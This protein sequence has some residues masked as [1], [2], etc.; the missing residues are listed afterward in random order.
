MEIILLGDPAA[1]KATQA[2]KLSRKFKLIDFDMGEELRKIQFGSGNAKLKKVLA[3]TYSKGKLTPTWLVRSILKKGIYAAPKS[4][5]ILF[6]GFPKMFGE[7]RLASKWLDAAG[8][9]QV[10]VFYLNIPEKEIIKRM[11]SRVEVVNGKKI[12]RTDDNLKA[13]HVRIKYFRTGINKVIEF[14]SKKYQFKKINGMGSV[15]AV[16]QRI[17]KAINEFQAQDQRRY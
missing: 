13:M 14:F 8:R 5:G 12:K 15:E 3:R 2:K 9:N 7:A 16:H 11:R 17:L 10:Y 1:G 6:D 4:K